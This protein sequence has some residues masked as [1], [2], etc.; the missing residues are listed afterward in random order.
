[1]KIYLEKKIQTSQI[2]GYLHKSSQKGQFEIQY[3]IHVVSCYY[4]AH[5]LDLD[6]KLS[7]ESY[8]FIISERH[9]NLQISNLFEF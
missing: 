2:N 6:H 3:M 8:F 1:M 4:E 5:L 9:K 7:K